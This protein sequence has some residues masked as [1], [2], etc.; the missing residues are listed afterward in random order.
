MSLPPSP[1]FRSRTSDIKFPL[2]A[3]TVAW[4]FSSC[5]CPS[6]PLDCNDLGTD[7]KKETYPRPFAPTFFIVALGCVYLAHFFW[8]RRGLG[9]F[10]PYPTFSYLWSFFKKMKWFLFTKTGFSSNASKDEALPTSPTEPPDTVMCF[11]SPEWHFPRREFLYSRCS[12]WC[13]TVRKSPA[14]IDVFLKSESKYSEL[15]FRINFF[16][17]P[18]RS[19]LAR[20][21]EWYLSTKRHISKYKISNMLF[22][23][24][25][26][27]QTVTFF[28]LHWLWMKGG[29][30]QV[31]F[32]LLNCSYPRKSHSWKGVCG[33]VTGKSYF[34]FPA[35]S[36]YNFF[37]PK[38]I[39]K[40]GQKNPFC[41]HL[42]DM[43]RYVGN[44]PIFELF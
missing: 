17:K 5:F 30:A 24:L 11:D 21:S 43:S 44:E 26:P 14:K 38:F 37:S 8:G 19:G 31:L 16:L 18:N 33:A 23:P 41:T 28:F 29:F 10:L 27:V 35:D 39:H 7:S 1:I 4:S 2:S 13:E 12:C 40:S 36:V 34:W 6:P 9:D 15:I 22:G 42:A 20:N 25:S 3:L 32:I